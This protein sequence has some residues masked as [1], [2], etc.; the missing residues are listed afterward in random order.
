[1]KVKLIVPDA[2]VVGAFDLNSN[3]LYPEMELKVTVVAA[4]VGVTDEIK[5]Q[6]SDATDPEFAAGT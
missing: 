1:L 2:A 4:A 5:T 6:L 3:F